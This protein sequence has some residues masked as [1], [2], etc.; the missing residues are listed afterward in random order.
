MKLISSAPWIEKWGRGIT[1]AGVQEPDIWAVFVPN[2]GNVEVGRWLVGEF[3]GAAAAKELVK[4]LTDRPWL[5]PKSESPHWLTRPDGT[6]GWCGAWQGWPYWWGMLN[7][8]ARLRWPDFGPWHVD[9]QIALETHCLCNLAE[10]WEKLSEGTLHHSD[11]LHHESCYYRMVG[12]YKVWVPD[13]TLVPSLAKFEPSDLLG[14]PHKDRQPNSPVQNDLRELDP[15]NCF[16]THREVEDGHRS[17]CLFKVTVSPFDFDCMRTSLKS[18]QSELTKTQVERDALLL[19]KENLEEELRRVNK[20][21]V[22][23]AHQQ[24]CAEYDKQALEGR[25]NAVVKLAQQNSQRNQQLTRSLKSFM[26]KHQQ[27]V[28]RIRQL[29]KENEGLKQLQNSEVTEMRYNFALRTQAIDVLRLSLILTA[30]LSIV[31]FLTCR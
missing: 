1:S 19:E 24:S 5:D 11:I 10:S 30:A 31:I 25:L 29:E 9:P 13:D 28:A 17:E 18:A 4:Y 7:G 27:D 6:R 2:I 16:C 26:Q 12:T 22:D 20:A 8:D 3:T 15:K 23:A 14:L 21:Y